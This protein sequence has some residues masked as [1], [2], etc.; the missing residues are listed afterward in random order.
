MFSRKIFLQK[1]IFI[2]FP[3]CWLLSTHGRTLCENFRNLP[4]RYLWK[5]SWNHFYSILSYTA[6]VNWF[7]PET[8]AW[9]LIER[10]SETIP[11]LRKR[12]STSGVLPFLFGQ[13]QGGIHCPIWARDSSLRLHWEGVRNTTTTLLWTSRLHFRKKAEHFWLLSLRSL[14][15]SAFFIWSPLMNACS[16]KTFKVT[17]TDANGHITLNTPVLVRSL[18]LSSVE[19]SQYLDGWPLGNT[20]CCWHSFLMF[21]EQEMNSFFDKKC[22]CAFCS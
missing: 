15:C 11:L 1:K 5:I 19:P 14:W 22:V 16:W 21:D 9:D 18:K 20:G 12:Q 4:S 6:P 3:H 2:V 8:R 17:L 7:G 10:V 13:V